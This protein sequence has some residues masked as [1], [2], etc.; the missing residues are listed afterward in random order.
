MECDKPT[1]PPV[2]PTAKPFGGEANRALRERLRGKSAAVPVW[3]VGIGV[4]R[5]C[6]EVE[7]GC[8]P[9]ERAEEEKEVWEVETSCGDSGTRA[10]EFLFNFQPNIILSMVPTDDEPEETEPLR[11]P[12]DAP[13][14]RLPRVFFSDRCCLEDDEE[15]AP[16]AVSCG[17][18]S[19][20]SEEERR[21]SSLKPAGRVPDGELSE[22]EGE[23]GE[24]EVGDTR[25]PSSMTGSKGG[26]P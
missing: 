5:T 19:A 26:A 15:S 14:C 2:P 24:T 7:K 3:E 4:A 25:P 10:L 12:G 8:G 9:K 20:R 11:E 13:E 1:G 23:G 22:A 21:P 17:G 16:I 6:V 18:R